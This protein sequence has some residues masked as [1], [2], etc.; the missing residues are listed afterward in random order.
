MA[1]HSPMIRVLQHDAELRRQ[2]RRQI[3][4]VITNQHH[5]RGYELGRL[6]HFLTQR[7]WRNIKLFRRFRACSIDFGQ[8][9]PMFR[10][11]AAR[12]RNAIS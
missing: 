7:G 11:D 6:L 4:L 2:G 8:F 3:R 5:L 12:Y 1:Q 10:L 9:A